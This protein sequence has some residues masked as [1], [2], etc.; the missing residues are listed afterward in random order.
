MKLKI[1][2]KPSLMLLIFLLSACSLQAGPSD[3]VITATYQ[4]MVNKAMNEAVEKITQEALLNPSATNT[5]V[6][7]TEVPPTNTE[8]PP[9]NTEVPPTALVETPTVFVPPT[10]APVLPTATF[11]PVFTP[12]RSDYNCQIA[13]AAPAWNASMS[14]G[15][16]FDGRWTFKNTGSNVWPMNNVDFVFISGTRFHGDKDVYDLPKDV[17]KGDSVEFIIDMLAP[18]EPGTYSAT[19]GL[20]LDGSLFCVTTIRIVVN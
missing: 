9:T 1:F 2:S 14:P 13:S 7:P 16:D 12:T 3:A 11:K 19:W 15:V 17:A 6:P 4:V 10:A 20:K 18:K 8:V 5:E